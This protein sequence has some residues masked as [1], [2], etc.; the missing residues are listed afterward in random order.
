MIRLSQASKTYYPR[1]RPPVVALKPTTFDIP[2]GEVTAILGE[3]GAGK[4]TAGRLINGLTRPTSGSV[5][6]DGVDIA[7]LGHRELVEA[8][9]RIG[10]VFQG[11]ALL[12]RRTA[13]QNVELPL[14][15]AGVGR[16]ARRERARELL[17]RVGLEA[18]AGAHPSQLSGGQ[19]QRVAIARALSARPEYLLA[20]EATSGL[21][22]ETTRSILG[23]LRELRDDLNLTVVLITHEM[24]VVRELADRA[25]LFE[26]GSVA[27]QAAVSEAV[28]TPGSRLGNLILPPV[29]V[30]PAPR[31][32]TTW[33]V[34]Y[35]VGGVAL[36]WPAALSA[37]LGVPVLLLGGI[38]EVINGDAAGRLY[39][40]VP[41]G[42]PAESILAAG[43]SLGLILQPR[44]GDSADAEKVTFAR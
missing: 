26:N 17:A 40:A 39:V 11:A 41:S 35:T 15:I 29:N 22:A 14:R 28:R 33:E 9:R 30:A 42:T 20:D 8:T 32:T 5:E 21:D 24:D 31:G 44:G 36:D 27:E 16:A 10:V 38:S 1:G 18:K 19:R 3:S 4:T 2:V 23:L 25:V 43:K 12:A 34:G 6:I 37:R 7:R 13:Q